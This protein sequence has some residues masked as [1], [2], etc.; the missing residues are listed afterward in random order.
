MNRKCFI[1]VFRKTQTHKK[2]TERK[3][4][5]KSHASKLMRTQSY[6]FMSFASTIGC[7]R[8]FIAHSNRRRCQHHMQNGKQPATNA[9]WMWDSQRM[10]MRA[11]LQ[12]MCSPKSVRQLSCRTELIR[13]IALS[14]CLATRWCTLSRLASISQIV[15]SRMLTNCVSKWRIPCM[16]PLKQIDG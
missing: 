9:M 4:W 14:R 8:T 10:K 15:F 1:W 16:N 11:R 6:A 7:Q 2:R 13:K 12:K 3:K 5:Q